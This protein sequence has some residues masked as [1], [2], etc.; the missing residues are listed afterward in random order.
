[1]NIWN[2]TKKDLAVIMKD[3]GSV[4]WIFILPVVFLLIFA[5]LASAQA[6]GS[7]KDEAEDT[8]TPI[9]VVNLDPHGAMAQRIIDA[10]DKS[11]SYRVVLSDEQNAEQRLEMIKIIWY[12]VIPEDFSANLSQGKPVSLTVVTHPDANIGQTRT[13]LQIING[14]A[15]DTSLELQLLD[16]IRQMGEMQAGN[17]QAEQVFQADKVMAQAKGQFDQSRITPLVA[18]DQQMLSIEGKQKFTF[19][20]GASAVPGM[21]VLFVFLSAASVARNI[22][23]ERK[24]GSLRR[25]LSAPLTRSELLL[26]KTLPIFLLTLV[27]IVVIFACGALIL[28]I[29]GIGTLSIGKS[30]L[31]W[32]LASIMIA[33]CSTS[34]GIMI[35]SLAKSEGQISGLSNALLWVAGFLGGAL[36]PTF[37]I[38]QIPTL[39]TLARM[40]PQ[41]WATRAYYDVI[42]RGAGV[43]D[44]LPSLGMLLLF[45]AVFFFI[46]VRRFRFE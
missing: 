11:E 29:L 18:V 23:E 41:S 17:P 20:L 10:L 2:L 30:P 16:G 5:G 37:L 31:A 24:D 19:D 34:L 43:A 36:L 22:Y 1:M 40:V 13:L 27:Q 6:G 32:A 9:T 45:S 42:A 12:V 3:R 7:S 33:V 14:I 4:L 26:G 35:S 44:I 15:R 21:A 46:G 25:L 39:N 28:P 8:R 38:E